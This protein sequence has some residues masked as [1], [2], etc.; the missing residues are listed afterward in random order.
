MRGLKTGADASEVQTFVDA[1]VERI[2]QL[3]H[4]CSLDVADEGR[5]LMRTVARLHGVRRQRMV[6]ELEEAKEAMLKGV[7]AAGMGR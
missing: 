4:T 5:H 3:E 6:Q 2:S 1:A 7:K